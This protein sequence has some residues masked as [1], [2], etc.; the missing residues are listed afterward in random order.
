MRKDGRVEILWG[1]VEL[2]ISAIFLVDFILYKKSNSLVLAVFVLLAASVNLL[3]RKG[4]YGDNRP[5]R[6][7]ALVLKVTDS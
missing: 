6:K 3:N 4:S 5:D 1:L 7:E 2:I